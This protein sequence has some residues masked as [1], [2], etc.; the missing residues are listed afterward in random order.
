MK[1]YPD[2]GTNRPLRS[3]LS[4]VAIS[5]ADNSKP[6]TSKFVIILD[7]VTDFGITI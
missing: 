2:I 1:A 4:I 3:K 6:K 7:F 5:S